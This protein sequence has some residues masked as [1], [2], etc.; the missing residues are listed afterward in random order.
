MRGR[1]LDP[2]PRKPP[3]PTE[4]S[5]DLL[6]TVRFEK[7]VDVGKARAQATA[8]DGDEIDKLIIFAPVASVER[9]GLVAHPRHILD[10]DPGNGRE[11]ARRGAPIAPTGE[12]APGSVPVTPR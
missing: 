11:A 12:V 1:T 4:R 9:V 2:T 8:L 5:V 3:S 6:A 7:R 10:D